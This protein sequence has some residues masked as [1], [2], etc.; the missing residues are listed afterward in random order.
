MH[1]KKAGKHTTRVFVA[2]AHEDSFDGSLID[3]WLT[4]GVDRGTIAGETWRT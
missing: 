4:R 3:G 1:L 2:S